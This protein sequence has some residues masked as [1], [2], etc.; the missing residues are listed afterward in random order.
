MKRRITYAVLFLVLFSIAATDPGCAERAQ[1]VLE[2]TKDVPKPLPVALALETVGLGLSVYLAIKNRKDRK[3]S[4]KAIAHFGRCYDAL[5]ESDNPEMKKAAE[6]IKAGLKAVN[7]VSE[8]TD[9]ALMEHFDN[10]RKSGG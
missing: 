8:I 1:R 2:D 4:D 7:H 6:T 5:K 9:R 10:V 3:Y